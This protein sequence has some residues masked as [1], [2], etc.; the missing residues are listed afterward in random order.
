[1][2]GLD[3]NVLLPAESGEYIATNAQYV[4]IHDKGIDKLS[5]EVNP[6]YAVSIQFTHC[7]LS[8]NSLLIF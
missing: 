4:K 3:E 5:D 2:D 8:N 6:K 7:V 1:M